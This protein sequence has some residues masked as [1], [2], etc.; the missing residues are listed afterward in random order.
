[1]PGFFH[2]RHAQPRPGREPRRHPPAPGGDNR[3][4]APLNQGRGVNPGDTTGWSRSRRCSR[5]AQPR[6][7]REP[8]RHEAQV[9]RP[10]VRRAAAQPRPGREPRRHPARSTTSPA[11]DRPLNQGRGVN[12]GDTPERR[13]YRNV[14]E[15][16]Q[17]RPGREPR[18]HQAAA[19]TP[20][21][22]Q[23]AQPRPGREPRRHRR[24]RR[25]VAGDD[26]ARSTKAGA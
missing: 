19:R 22:G 17:P 9:R 2:R 1:M 13:S 21:S 24:C 5:S 15:I 11:C 6:P 20:Q 4:A 10:D 3:R 26:A 18:R 14:G 16:A 23:C 25:S 12:P 8:R 7:G